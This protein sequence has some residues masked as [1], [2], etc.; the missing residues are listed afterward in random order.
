VKHNQ[1]LVVTLSLIFT[2]YSSTLTT[3]Q[4]FEHTENEFA[5]DA[6]ANCVNVALN[7]LLHS[8]NLLQKYSENQDEVQV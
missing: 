8:T 1:F 7:L 2:T 3:T 5:V 4:A 6:R